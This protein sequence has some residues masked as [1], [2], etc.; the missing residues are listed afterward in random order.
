ENNG[1][2]VKD[3]IMID[4][5]VPETYAKETPDDREYTKA[6]PIAMDMN[7]GKDLYD[8]NTYKNLYI[9]IDINAIIKTMQENKRL[10]QKITVNEMKVFYNSWILNHKA[11]TTHRPIKQTNAQIFI[12]HATE[13]L[14]LYLTETLNM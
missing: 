2:V 6:F 12:I 9:D 1:D 4:S 10:P 11:L 13:R 8:E 14:P 5:L 7:F 3:I